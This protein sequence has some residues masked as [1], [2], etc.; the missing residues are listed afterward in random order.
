MSAA[1]C[2]G[3]AV[4]TLPPYGIDLPSRPCL[5]FCRFRHCSPRCW[6][7]AGAWTA[8]PLG[9]LLGSAA[10]AGAGVAVTFLAMGVLLAAVVGYG[11]FNPVFREMDR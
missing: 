9:I 8:I 5:L 11:Y 10:V 1:D 2:S 7:R 6:S 4:P 3:G